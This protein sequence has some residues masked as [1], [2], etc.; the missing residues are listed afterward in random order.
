[1]LIDIKEVDEYLDNKYYHLIDEYSLTGRVLT[2]EMV[3][4]YFSELMPLLPPGYVEMIV[5]ATPP[6]Y[7]KWVVDIADRYLIERELLSEHK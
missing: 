4:E 3:Q 1:M 5:T 7:R 6:H 2:F